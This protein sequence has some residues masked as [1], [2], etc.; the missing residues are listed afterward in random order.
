[1]KFSSVRVSDTL[2]KLV[3]WVFLI[4]VS[5][6]CLF[7]FVW[8]LSTSMK[9]EAEAF[10]IPPTWIPLEPTGDSY[11]GIWLILRHKTGNS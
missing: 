11:V 6:F 4:A 8:M 7:P 3:V 10:R 9:T 2:I 1:M 5:V